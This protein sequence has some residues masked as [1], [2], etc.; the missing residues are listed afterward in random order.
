V[1]MVK[2]PSLLDGAG[3]FLQPQID[4]RLSDP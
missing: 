4:T 3:N 1:R 2:N